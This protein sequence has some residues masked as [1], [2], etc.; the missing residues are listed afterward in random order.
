MSISVVVVVALICIV[1][2]YVWKLNRGQEI[3]RLQYEHKFIP[4]PLAKYV[5]KI[6]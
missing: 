1:M 6:A 3:L 2:L 5:N 4:L